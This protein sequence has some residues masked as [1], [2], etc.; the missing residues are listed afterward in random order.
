MS[1]ILEA[2]FLL[3][4]CSVFPEL[5]P[6]SVILSMVEEFAR[7]GDTRLKVLLFKTKENIFCNK[8]F[9][10]KMIYFAE[11]VKYS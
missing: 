5:F 11:K 9:H 10:N 7:N 2:G 4:S 3:L 1:A 6:I 8:V